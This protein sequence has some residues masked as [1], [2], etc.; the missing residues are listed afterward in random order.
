MISKY[1]SFDIY[2]QNTRGLRTKSS[3]FIRNIVCSKFSA[4]VITETWL[5]DDISSSDYFP[6]N[7]QIFRSDRKLTGPKQKG[8]GVLVAVD[9]SVQCMRRADLETLDESVWLEVGLTK[10]EKLLIGAFIYP[11]MY[12]LLNL[13]EHS[14]P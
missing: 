4:V 2:Y 1:E 6:S 5:S 11:R 8:G 7:Y 3:E 10:G 14:H 12:Y 13:I 9:H